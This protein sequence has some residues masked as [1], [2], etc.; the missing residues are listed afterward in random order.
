MPSCMLT[1]DRS[2]GSVE[3]GAWA[4]QHWR[5][6]QRT[7]IC[8]SYSAMRCVSCCTS[9]SRV[10]S[11]GDNKAHQLLDPCNISDKRN[12]ATNTKHSFHGK[13]PSALQHRRIPTAADTDALAP[14]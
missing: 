13:H 14:V 8:S 6:L 5:V 7:A 1:D 10:A 9:S 4:L 12:S 11:C 3:S 2:D